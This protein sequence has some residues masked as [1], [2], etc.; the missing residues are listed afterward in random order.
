MRFKNY[1]NELFT[2]P[3]EFEKING[4]Y[5]FT[6]DS[7]KFEVW[8]T[9][10]NLEFSQDNILKGVE[11]SFSKNGSTE[12]NISKNPYRIFA[13]IF[14]IVNDYNVKKLNYIEFS[15]EFNEKSRLKLYKT[16]AIKLMKELGWKTLEVD[17]QDDKIYYMIYKKKIK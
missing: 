17:D 9:K 13:T 16:L 15:S 8:F 11:I 3:Y 7:D 2:D 14:K 6:D 5:K 1:L 10:K 12:I 4:I